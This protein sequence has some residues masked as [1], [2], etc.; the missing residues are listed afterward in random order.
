MTAKE[1]KIGIA[2]AT[3]RM[4]KMLIAEVWRHNGCTLSGAS[5]T[6][7]DP[8]CGRDAGEIAGIGRIGVSLQRNAVGL[9]ESSDVVIDFTTPAA[10]LEHCMLANRYK[11]AL[12]IGTTGFNP[13]QTEML[14]HHGRTIPI[15]G[16]PN[17][18]LG[19]NILISLTEQLAHLLD[20][21]Y[22]IE[23]FEMHHRHKI[24]A[25]SGTA[26]ALGQAAARGR[27]VDLDAVEDRARDGQVGARRGGHIGFSVARGGDVIGDH[28]VYFAAEG[29]R[30]ELTHRASNRNIYARGAVHAA[31]WLAD[32]PAGLYTMR[33]VVQAPGKI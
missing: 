24:D 5:V 6:E 21:E 19:V 7:N 9:F 29:E 10:S 13:A 12:V 15:V 1:L 14:K 32:K 16:S 20:D 30:I 17:M 26:L 27:K 23:V 25:P 3:G 11:R 22:D 4:G 33:D 18:S 28:T 8:M 2:G 31:L